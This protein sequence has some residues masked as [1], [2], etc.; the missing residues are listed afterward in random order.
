MLPPGLNYCPQAN[1]NTA[2]PHAATRCTSL[3]F[4]FSPHRRLHFVTFFRSRAWALPPRKGA[5]LSGRGLLCIVA[6]G[7]GYMDKDF[8]F[9]VFLVTKSVSWRW[10]VYWE[11][12]PPYLISKFGLYDNKE[13]ELFK[14]DHKIG[15]SHNFQ[16]IGIRYL[17]LLHF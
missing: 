12:F 15:Q 17:Y 11:V 7:K 1:A 3:F 4:F 10:Q 5:L 8:P 13:L 14:S 6:N 16:Q 2:N 9:R